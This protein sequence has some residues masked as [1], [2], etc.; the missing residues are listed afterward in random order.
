MGH[1]QGD[2]C[3]APRRRLDRGG[4]GSLVEAG[5]GRGPARRHALAARAGP[6]AVRPR[7]GAP[8][9]WLAPGRA[10]STFS[11][12][13]RGS[14]VRSGTARGARRR[15]AAGDG[16][17]TAAAGPPRYR[18]LT[19]SEA[20]VAELAASGRS[21]REIAQDLFV[22]LATVETHLTRV[23]RKVEST[24]ASA[25]PRRWPPRT[26]ADCQPPRR[27]APANRAGRGQGELLEVGEDRLDDARV[28]LVSTS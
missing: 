11:R 22:T 19:P 15:R 16:R 25:W 17:P 27:L 1:G 5:G 12:D 18:A 14:R 3:R 21:N 26:A 24:A 7:R 9:G 2:R 13:G 8:R 6:N 10:S 4:R 20:R 28:E 23:Y